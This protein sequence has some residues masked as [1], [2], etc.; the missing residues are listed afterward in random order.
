MQHACAILSSDKRHDF[1]EKVIEYKM[2]I[3]TLSTTFF[4]TVLILRRIQRDIVIKVK[5]S[6]CKVGVIR[7]GFW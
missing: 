2:C 7:V 5:T 4:E 6:L 1:R 3:L